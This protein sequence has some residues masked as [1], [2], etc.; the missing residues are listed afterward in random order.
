[1]QLLRPS[2]SFMHLLQQSRPFLNSA[3]VTRDHRSLEYMTKDDS[4]TVCRPVG[5]GGRWHQFLS[6]FLFD[7]VYVPG[8]NQE[9]PDTLSSWSYPA[10]LYSPETNIHITEE[11]AEG[12]AA[13]ERGQGAHADQLLERAEGQGETQFLRNFVALHSFLSASGVTP[14]DHEVD[15]FQ[16]NAVDIFAEFEDGYAMYSSQVRT[17]FSVE[18]LPGKARCKAQHVA[19]TQRC[20][21]NSSDPAPGGCSAMCA[22]RLCSRV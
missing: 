22:C 21:Q 15:V 10:Y 5:R 2:I 19:L 16:D 7:V 4:V 18:S 13:H 8:Q 11:D 12:E 20:S 17:L 1:M 14:S 3:L 9:S 6:H